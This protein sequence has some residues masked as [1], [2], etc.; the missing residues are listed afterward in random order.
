MALIQ[1]DSSMR[2]VPAEA[3]P[4]AKIAWIAKQSS[5]HHNDGVQ[6]WFLWQTL[7]KFGPMFSWHTP[8]SE[9]G[10]IVEFEYTTGRKREVQPEDCLGLVLVWTQT[11]GLLNVLQL[12]FGLTYTNLSIY[13]RFGVRIFVK[14]FRDDGIS[15]QMLLPVLLPIWITNGDNV[16]N[17][18]SMLQEPQS[19]QG[20]RCY[21]SILYLPITYKLKTS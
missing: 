18:H 16:V 3:V 12:V 5:I 17:N 15:S 4:M 9:S 6:F 10:M 21:P 11:R 2:P 19:N 13:L 7:L 1:K 20:P 8:F 14:T